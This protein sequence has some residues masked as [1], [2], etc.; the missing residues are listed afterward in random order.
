MSEVAAAAAPAPETVTVKIDGKDVAVPKG[1]NV[2]EAVLAARGEISYFC[3]HPGLSVVAVCRQCLIEVKGQPKLVPACQ[4]IVTPGMEISSSS[5]KVLEARRAML[6]FTLLSHPIDCPICDKAGECTLQ[7][8]YMEWDRKDARGADLVKIR[9]PKVV[10]VGPRIVLDAERCILCTRCIRV[11]DEVAGEHEL[12]MAWRGAHQTLSTAPGRKLEN[13]YSLNTVDVCP[14]GALTSKDFRFKRRVWEL[15]AS[16]SICTGCATGCS[17][18]IHHAN[19]KVHRLVPRENQSVNKHWMCDDGRMTYREL[20]EERVVEARI[21]RVEA[22]LADAIAEAAR[23]IEAARPAVGFVLSAQATNEDNWLAAK[24]ALDVLGASH[25]YVAGRAPWRGDAILRSADR[26]P[27]RRGVEM[28]TRGRVKP[29]SAIDEDLRAE[30]VK[31]LYV[32][33]GGDDVVFGA[34]LDALIVATCRASQ[35]ASK[36]RVLLPAAAWAEVDG[37]MTNAKGM[38]QRLRSVVPPPGDARP[39]HELLARIARGLGAAIEPRPA[40]A[41][42]DEMR[43]AIPAIA[44]AAWGR[45]WPPTLLR[46]A[47][48]RG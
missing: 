43:A 33:D 9:K 12:E 47:A 7:K 40:R 1:T 16:P 15:S 25:V 2:L 45:D 39:H 34:P 38:V 27:N 46:F 31:V 41:V 10:D 22:K 19:G 32:I 36:A 14:V 48:S 28:V 3:Y 20:Y 17:D 11:C 24:L 37:T 18:E 23:L 42:F 21:A 4:M 29:A 35:L 44:P 26:N 5:P 30:R 13:P 6:E 8:L